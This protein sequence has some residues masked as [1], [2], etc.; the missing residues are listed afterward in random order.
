MPPMSRMT[1]SEIGELIETCK[2]SI[3]RKTNADNPC[4]EF[5]A[6]DHAYAYCRKGDRPPSDLLKDQVRLIKHYFNDGKAIDLRQLPYF[7]AALEQYSRLGY[8]L[9]KAVNKARQ[10]VDNPS[11][12]AQPKSVVE[13]AIVDNTIRRQ[14][15]VE[16]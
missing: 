2:E 4:S 13:F 6:V 15:R 8:D 16:A 7:A 3:R 14:K 1:L 11:G 12:V 10:V 9:K 5:T